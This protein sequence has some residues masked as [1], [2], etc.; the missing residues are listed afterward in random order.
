MQHEIPIKYYS[1]KKQTIISKFYEGLFAKI[2]SSDIKNIYTSFIRKINLLLK[3]KDDFAKDTTYSYNRLIS[4]TLFW[5]F[6]ILEN[7]DIEYAKYS[8]KEF[9]NEIVKYLYKNID[10]FETQRSSFAKE[11]YNRYNMISMFFEERFNLNLNIYLDY[12]LDF[13]QRNKDITPENEERISFDDL[14]IN[15]PEPSSIAIIDVCRQMERQ[16]FLIRPPYQRNEVI[17]Q[18]KSSSIIESIILGIKLPPIFVFKRQDGISEVLDGQQRLL[19]ILAFIQKPYLDEN[20]N[21]RYSNKNGFSL[22]LKNGILKNLHGKKIDQLSI[23][24][25][26]RI[27]ILIYG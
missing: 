5:A 23:E 6:S 20:N 25:Q 12:N 24:N 3:I 19:S 8:N 15:K 13:K 10:A 18:K 4:E 14:R 17:N 9:I 1:V 2:D 16:K 7:E 11:L 26:E 27:K 22:N 21:I